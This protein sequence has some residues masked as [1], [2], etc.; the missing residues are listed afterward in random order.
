MRI[1][2]LPGDGVGPEVTAQAVRVLTAIVGNKAS[3]ELKEAAV[4]AA[5]IADSGDP[6]PSGTMEIARKADAILFGSVGGPGE[7]SLPFKERPGSGL[8]RLRKDLSLF[9][10][11]RPAFLFPELEDASTL[12]PE[13]VSGL[14][15]IIL[16]EL[17]GD[18]YFGEPRG[19]HR[20]ASGERFGVN[21]MRYSE[22]EIER[23]AHVGFKLARSRRG[24]L[25]SVDKANVLETMQLWRE[26]VT[27]VGKEYPEVTLSHLFVDAAAMKLMRAP[28][29]FDVIVTGNMFGDIL[30][31]AAAMLTGSIGMLPSASLGA[32]EKKGLYEPVHGT[33]PDIAGQ[34][35][36]NPLAA[37]MSCAMMLRYS[38]GMNEA[39]ALIEKSVRSVLSEGFRTPDI[40][41]PGAQT[42]GTKEMGDAVVGAIKRLSS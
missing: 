33:A 25:C 12:K 27:R 11:I 3:L 23:I 31:D 41:K 30:S 6:L 22:S 39:A 8:L 14:D 21:T 10:N 18:V 9:A 17:N 16:R 2:V 38:F 7:E 35:I 24:R 15:L 34:D 40:A 19:I 26:V 1:A 4:G 29:D 42:I 28:K 13:I 37:I 36:A 20:D 32:D 5:G